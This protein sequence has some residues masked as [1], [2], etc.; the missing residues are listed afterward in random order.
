MMKEI[1]IGDRIHEALSRLVTGAQ[2][3]NK[4]VVSIPVVY[5]SGS[6]AGVEIQ[7]NGDDCFVSD[8]GQGFN[9][10]QN[11]GADDFY[12]NCAKS[13]SDRFGT[14]FDGLNMF[15]LKASLGK[16]EAAIVAVANASAIAARESVERAAVETNRKNN[17]R[18]FERVSDVFGKQHVSKTAELKGRHIAWDAHNVVTISGQMS[19]F[20]FVSD[21]PNSVSNKFM[22]FS[23]I[24]KSETSSAILNAVVQDISKISQKGQLIGDVADNIVP[25]SASNEQFMSYA[26]VA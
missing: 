19:I 11:Y 15:V 17:S 26:K 10:A 4:T 2:F 1:T 22:M 6:H 25:F 3:G 20:E 12:R 23:D 14:G 7:I 21:H 24:R 18:L 9:E 13:S 8:A 16:I 5:P